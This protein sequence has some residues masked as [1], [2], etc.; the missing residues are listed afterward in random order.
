VGPRRSSKALPSNN[1]QSSKAKRPRPQSRQTTPAPQTDPRNTR[2]GSAGSE[3]PRPAIASQ[4]FPQAAGRPARVVPSP[5]PP[6][7]RKRAP[8]M[9][10]GAPSMT[11]SLAQAATAVSRRR[12]AAKPTR[13][14]PVISIA[15]VAGSGIAA[16]VTSTLS[17]SGPISSALNVRNW[18]VSSPGVVGMNRYVNV[19]QGSLPGMEGKKACP[20]KVKPGPVEPISPPGWLQ[21]APAMLM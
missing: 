10:R 15:Q 21:L 7:Q 11:M 9:T 6:S 19:V 3:S 18:S 20:E 16:C 8:R 5:Q 1:T 4:D 17:T 2:L 12:R 14:K 13:P